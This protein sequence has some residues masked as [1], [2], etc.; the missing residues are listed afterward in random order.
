MIGKDGW[1]EQPGAL[2]GESLWKFHPVPFAPR[3]GAEIHAYDVDG[4]GDNDVIT[5]LAAHE[6]G[7]SWWEQS[8]DGFKEHLIMGDRAP[9]NRYGVVF[10]EL[11]S[12]AL[13]GHVMAM[14]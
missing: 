8:P 2:G 12:V 11:H 3:G 10:S 7:L 1:F 13:A 14:G 9:L 5:S 4:D 6:F